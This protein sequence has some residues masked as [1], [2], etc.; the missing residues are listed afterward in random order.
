MLFYERVNEP[1]SQSNTSKPAATANSELVSH[2]FNFDLSN[3]L[4]EWIWKD[5]TS[6]LQDKNIFCHHYFM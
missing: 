3:E 6:F 4:A 2:S 1:S 5:N